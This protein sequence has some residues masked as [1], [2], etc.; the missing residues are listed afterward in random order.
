MLSIP[1]IGAITVATILGEVGDLRGYHSAREIIKLAGLNLYEISSGE[2]NGQ[3][4]I[5][6]RGKP[7]LRLIL[8][9]ASLRMIRTKGTFNEFYQRL[10]AKGKAKTKA[11]VASMCKLIRIIFALVKNEQMYKERSYEKEAQK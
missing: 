7:L 11:I 3:K 5:T 2:H 1:G 10:T 9:M 6:K 4:R 8:Y